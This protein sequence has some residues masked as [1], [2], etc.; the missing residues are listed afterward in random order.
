MSFYYF[1]FSTLTHESPQIF[2]EWFRYDHEVHD[3][4]TRAGGD[5]IR[6][7]YFDVGYVEQSY[8]LHT[9]GAKNKYGEK[10]IQASGP[11][12]WNSIPDH[13]QNAGTLC[14]FKKHLKKHFIAQYAIN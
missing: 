10:M 3:H 6:E 9:K 14:T 5:V 1:V 12:I 13:I 2:H 7:H 8:A 11:I 4:T